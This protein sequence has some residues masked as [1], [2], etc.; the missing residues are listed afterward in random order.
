MPKIERPAIR[1][2]ARHSDLDAEDLN[3]ALHREVYADVRDW[4]WLVRVLL[5]SLG[6]GFLASG[7]LF[8]FAFNW[9]DIPK[10]GKIALAAVAVSVPAI[11]AAIPWLSELTRKG[12]LTTAAF[13]VG[14]LFGV[15]GQIYQTG[16]NAYDLF[17]GWVV[18]ILVWVVAMDFAPLW[19]LWLVLVNTT[20]TLYAEQ[21]A[22]D[23]PFD[24]LLFGLCA[25]N[26][27]AAGGFAFARRF[28]RG[29]T[30]PKWLPRVV[31][32]SAIVC[33][34]IACVWAITESG[35]TGIFL[36]RVL[37]TL[38]LY[39]GLVGI[40][41]QRKS[42]FALASIALSVMVIVSALLVVNVDDEGGFF[43][44][45]LWVMAATA[46]SIVGLNH[47]RKIWRHDEA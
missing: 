45:T 8:F 22:F 25:L 12:L 7:I 29:E 27:T 37:P 4:R 33:S 1:L 26:L 21:V 32:P 34:T 40:C 35:H 43:L 30:Y 47:Y 24:L 31:F 28:G 44:T 41:L 6:L 39:A 9:Q 3:V 36:T 18:F 10:F 15:L 13:L 14:P 19:L 11:L 5:L 16:A 46:G 17:L 2:L 38:L 23:W 20:I 42:L